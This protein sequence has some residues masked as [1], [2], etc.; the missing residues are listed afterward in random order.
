ML[1]VRIC[2]P[3]K[4][5]LSLSPNLRQNPCEIM[6]ADFGLISKFPRTCLRYFGAILSIGACGFEFYN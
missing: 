2:L 6:S 5:G 4:V 3:P 1:E